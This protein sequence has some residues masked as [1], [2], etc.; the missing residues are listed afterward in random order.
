[1]YCCRI[2]AALVFSYRLGGAADSVVNHVIKDTRRTGR[3][4]KQ[5]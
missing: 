1:M 4:S 3:P 5:Q 2:G